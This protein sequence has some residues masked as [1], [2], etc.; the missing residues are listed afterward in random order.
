MAVL[1]DRLEGQVT[2]MAQF[3]TGPG[4]VDQ[5]LGVCF[6]LAQDPQGSSWVG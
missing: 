1:R 2:N 3:G 4:A 5:V 6:G